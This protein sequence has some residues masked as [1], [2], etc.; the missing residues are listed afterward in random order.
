MKPTIKSGPIPYD[1]AMSGK[2]SGEFFGKR[3]Q[4]RHINQLRPWELF[5]VLTEKYEWSTRDAAEFADFLLPMLNYN[6][7]DRATAYE[8]LHH[9][10]I[11]GLYA[12][13]Y[14]L[15]PLNNFSTNP[16]LVNP[17]G[18]N[19]LSATLP[20]YSLNMLHENLRST[21]TQLA[22]GVGGVPL[23]DPNLL[24]AAGGAG[25]GA[26]FMQHMLNRTVPGAT[27]NGASQAWVIITSLT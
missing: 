5:E 26:H 15:K 3:G 17:N 20:P 1:I 8:C 24:A 27:P 23:M 19:L 9:P 11:S 12:D 16:A 4:L 18:G 2:Y 21:L 6:M 7:Y 22:A 25:P 10:W 14:V 13:D